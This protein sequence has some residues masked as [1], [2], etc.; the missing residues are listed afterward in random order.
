MQTARI[1]AVLH[2]AGKKRVDESILRPAWYFQQNIGSLAIVLQAMEQADV[3]KIVFSSTAAVYGEVTDPVSEE[4]PANPLNPYGAS[5]FFCEVL[6]ESAAK[7]QRLEAISLRYFNVAGADSAELRDSAIT[8]LI[9]I[10]VEQVSRGES[11]KIFGDDFPTPDGTC[12]RDFIHVADLADAHLAVLDLD[13]EPGKNH[14]LNV[15]TGLGFSVRQVVD[16]VNSQFESD[17][18]ATVTER[19]V[20]DPANVVARADKIAALTGWSPRKS[21]VDIISSTRL[22]FGFAKD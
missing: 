7:S 12:I 1:E 20:G 21:L 15:G 4:S 16:E 5:K 2:F 6:L 22:A 13:I 19:R 9:P 14:I 3:R 10:V 18:E 11:P 8:N 17:I